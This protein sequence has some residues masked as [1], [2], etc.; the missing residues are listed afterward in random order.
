MEERLREANDRRRNSEAIIEKTLV[1][2][3]SC[4]T[5]I[6]E[7]KALLKS[8]QNERGLLEREL[9]NSKHAQQDAEE[10]QQLLS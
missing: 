4:R 1:D 5:K 6:D 7:L 8:Q 2:L 9:E 10:K 3:G